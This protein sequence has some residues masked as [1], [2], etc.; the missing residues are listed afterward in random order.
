LGNKVTIETPEN[1]T[2]NFLNA[3]QA[4]KGPDIVIWAH[5]KVGEWADAGIISPIHMSPE[6]A[7]K[8]YPKVWQGVSHR[9][10]IW[11][12]PIALETVTLIYNKKLLP[13]LPPGDLAQLESLNRVIKTKH[14]GV[15][16]QL[17]RYKL[18]KRRHVFDA[19]FYL[20]PLDDTVGQLVW[21]YPVPPGLLFNFKP[22]EHEN[23]YTLNLDYRKFQIA[24][25]DTHLPPSLGESA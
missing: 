17:L 9:D 3:V 24:R 23:A 1:L 6:F 2:T 7:R 20:A 21:L 8:F 13:G 25:G 14:P 4:S 18:A 5:D 12:Y 15:R 10:A 16:I 19:V 22:E 11:G